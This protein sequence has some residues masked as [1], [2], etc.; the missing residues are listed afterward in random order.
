MK[1]RLYCP[2]LNIKSEEQSLSRLDVS[3]KACGDGKCTGGQ[4]IF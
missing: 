2:H 3:K 1:E 4:F